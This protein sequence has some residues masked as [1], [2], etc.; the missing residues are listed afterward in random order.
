MVIHLLYLTHPYNYLVTFQIFEDKNDSYTNI[1]RDIF[2]F[3]WFKEYALDFSIEFVYLNNYY[4][5]SLCLYYAIM[6]L[7]ISIAIP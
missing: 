6:A 2:L 4:Y 7:E 5:C 1:E 3:G